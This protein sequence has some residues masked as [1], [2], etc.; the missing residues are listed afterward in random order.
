[1]NDVASFKHSRR[2]R[3]PKFAFDVFSFPFS[4]QPFCVQEL[5]SFLLRR[6]P[7][8]KRLVFPRRAF[9]AKLFR[10]ALSVASSK[11][12]SQRSVVRQR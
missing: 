8:P 6:Q 3:A 9:D 5:T 7:R 10:D 12:F 1:M 4:T 2:T 11:F